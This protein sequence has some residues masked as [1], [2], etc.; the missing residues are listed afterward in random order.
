MGLQLQGLFALCDTH[1]KEALH[2]SWNTVCA[3]EYKPGS[4]SDQSPFPP[5]LQFLNL[6]S[7]HSCFSLI[8]LLFRSL[9]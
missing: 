9:D 7:P 6:L 3:Q 2:Y 8:E 1:R 4:A 5:K